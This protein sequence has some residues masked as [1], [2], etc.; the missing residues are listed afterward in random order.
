[1]LL[2]KYVNRYGTQNPTEIPPGWTE[3][4]G[5][6]DPYTYRYYGVVLNENGVLHSYP[7]TYTT[8]L[9]AQKAVD[10]VRRRA[11][12]PQPFF[13]RLPSPPP[14]AVGPNG[15][16]HPPG[17]AF[18]SAKSFHHFASL[19]PPMPPSF[20]EQDVSDKPRAIQLLPPLNSANIAMI[21]QIYHREL[22]TLLSVD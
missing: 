13:L 2:G 17:T 15:P 5:S 14:P 12:S 1:I 20:N 8:D 10:I 9:E 11:P 19:P 21:A 3:F 7:S 18:P 22:E 6:V 4:Y 16:G